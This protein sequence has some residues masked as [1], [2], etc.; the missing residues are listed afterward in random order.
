MIPIW[1]VHCGELSS[2]QSELLIARIKIWNT[3]CNWISVWSCLFIY[4]PCRSVRFDFR[5]QSIL[6]ERTNRKLLFETMNF[7]DFSCIVVDLLTGWTWNPSC[8]TAFLLRESSRVPQP[9]VT[10][11]RRATISGI[12]SASQS[13][14]WTVMLSPGKC[15]REY[16]GVPPRNVNISQLI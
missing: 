4:L 9:D 5:H 7:Y 8:P 11:C 2:S 15:D 3:N 10:A 16:G 12:S 13:R 6:R 14:P 1:R